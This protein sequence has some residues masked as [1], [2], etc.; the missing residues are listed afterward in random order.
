M[1]ALKLD[2]YW[3]ILDKEEGDIRRQQIISLW[4]I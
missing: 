4:E 2:I 1:N 3:V